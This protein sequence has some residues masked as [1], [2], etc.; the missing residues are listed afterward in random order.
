MAPGA[1]AIV[2][3]GGTG[4][5]F[6]R[7]KQYAELAGRPLIDWAC[8]AGRAACRGV[9]LVVPVADVAGGDRW[10]ADSGGGG[11]RHPV[12]VGARRAGRRCPRT[13][14]WWSCTTPPGPWPRNHCGRRWSAAVQAGADAAVP[15]VAVTDTVKMV[16]PDGTLATLDRGRL[17]AVQTPQAFPRRVLRRAHAGGDDATDDAALVERL[18]G[19]VVA[20]DGSP[21][22][23][24]VTT[25]LDLTLAAALAA[26][27]AAQEARP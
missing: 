26:G 9:V 19:R 17:V 8:A 21:A 20:V 16:E 18:G 13:P 5:R 7:P 14:R 10:D 22:N 15:A 12:G 25:P 1:W 23:L 27:D 6:G 3:A 24:K 2:V 4:A 11:R